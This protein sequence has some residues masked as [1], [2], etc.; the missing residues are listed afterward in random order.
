MQP[1]LLRPGPTGERCHWSR[2]LP[3][4]SRMTPQAGRLVRDARIGGTHEGWL[5]A[6]AGPRDPLPVAPY[7]PIKR[8][9]N[10]SP[11]GRSAT[12]VANTRNSVPTHPT[13]PIKAVAALASTS[14]RWWPGR[15]L[16]G[17]CSLPRCSVRLKMLLCR[18]TI[19]S[20]RA[21]ARRP[22]HAALR[23][24]NHKQMPQAQPVKAVPRPSGFGL[25]A[26]V[27]FQR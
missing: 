11:W 13:G 17:R 14:V 16:R 23:Q 26:A 12:D 25:D 4:R 7:T 10:R 6:P 8:R 5:P 1:S 19:P 2:S 20:Q 22:A 27:G 18:R 15:G 21:A 24:L 9:R 3:R